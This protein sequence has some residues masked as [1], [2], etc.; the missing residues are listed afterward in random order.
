[1]ALG[2]GFGAGFSPF[3]PGTAGSVVGIACY[4]PLAVAGIP[5]LAAAIVLLFLA[6]IWAAGVCGAR[7]GDHDHGRI[8]VD[9]VVGMLVTLAGVP[10]QPV[11]LLAGFLLFRL[12]DIVKPFPAGWIDRHWRSPIG[13]MA[14]DVVAGVYANFVLQAARLL[15]VN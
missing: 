8:V 15:L 5:A 9:E 12:S 4:L 2:T 14:D 7:Y 13:V 11:W 3:A 6:G 1:M 10:S